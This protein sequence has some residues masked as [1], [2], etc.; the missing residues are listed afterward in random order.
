MLHGACV[1]GESWS[2]KPCVFPCKVASAGDEGYLVCAAGAA[3]LLSS[4][5]RFSLGG[6]QH[7]VVHVCVVL[8]G[9]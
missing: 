3:A 4:S 2:T 8:C 9:S 6:L 5:N 1:R 7:V